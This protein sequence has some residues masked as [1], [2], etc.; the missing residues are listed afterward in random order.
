MRC[1][2]ETNCYWGMCWCRLR[3]RFGWIVAYR[4]IKAISQ[5]CNVLMP[6]GT[7]ESLLHFRS[8]FQRKLT[9]LRAW[10]T[11]S[12]SLLYDDVSKSE[13]LQS[14]TRKLSKNGYFLLH[15]QFC[16]WRSCCH[17]PEQ[18][19][20]RS[21]ITQIV[22][23]AVAVSARLCSAFRIVYHFQSPR[24]ELTTGR[25]SENPWAMSGVDHFKVLGIEETSTSDDIKKAYFG[26][27]L[28]FTRAQ[29]LLIRLLL[30]IRFFTTLH[31]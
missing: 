5:A 15:L 1:W 11:L 7:T 28:T 14:Q 17:K 21:K 25:F 12:L 13:Q 19:E 10:C 23:K 9:D 29:T 26:W 16:K 2:S 31:S 6:N 22:S 30:G 8:C 4:W 27:E 24:I 3:W 18:H 20:V